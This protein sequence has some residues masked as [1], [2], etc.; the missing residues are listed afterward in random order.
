M[1]QDVVDFCLVEA[2]QLEQLIPR[3]L[4]YSTYSDNWSSYQKCYDLTVLRVRSP[5]TADHL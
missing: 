3:M 5:Y 4:T 2:V 1:V